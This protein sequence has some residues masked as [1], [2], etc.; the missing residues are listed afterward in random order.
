MYKSM[1]FCDV[2]TGKPKNLIHLEPI[3]I[4]NAIKKLNLRH[5]VITSVDRDDLIDG[6]ANHFMKLL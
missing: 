5:A 3:K 4:S 1:C 6:G 2:I